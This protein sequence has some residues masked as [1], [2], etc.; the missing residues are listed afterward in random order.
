VQ[1]NIEEL[2]Q[3]KEECFSVA[4]QC[5]IKFK[6]NFAKVGVFS[7]DQNFI[8]GDPEGVIKWI[9]CEVEAFH[10]VLTSRG[11]FFLPV[12]VPKGLCLCLRRMAA[13]MRRL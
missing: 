13:N 1:K 11:D 6:N 7:T 9:E 3:A 10:E 12:W 5:S 4:M 2:C 8:R